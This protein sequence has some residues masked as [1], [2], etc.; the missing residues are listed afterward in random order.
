MWRTP[1]IPGDDEEYTGA[2]APFTRTTEV[3]F[4]ANHRP[5]SREPRPVPERQGVARY[6]SAR[7]RRRASMASS[8]STKKGSASLG[9][10]QA[11]GWYCT[12]RA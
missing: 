6:S 8:M 7:S 2:Q 4:H 12:E 9:P 11:S 1:S 5:L 10:G 3:P